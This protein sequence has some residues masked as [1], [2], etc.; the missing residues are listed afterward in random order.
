M[1]VNETITFT[2]DV[3][4]SAGYDVRPVLVQNLALIDVRTEPSTPL[5]G[6]PAKRYFT[7]L[8]VKD[9][10]AKVQF[11]KF[12]R[13]ELPN[14][15]YEDPL[16]IKVEKAEDPVGTKLAVGGWTSFNKPTP[17]DHDA[18]KEVLKGLVGVGYEPLLVTKQVVA[19]THFI[20]LSRATLVYPG[21]VPYSA[22]VHIYK[23]PTAEAKIV[24]IVSLGDPSPH[25]AGGYTAFRGIETEQEALDKALKDFTGSTFE[26]EYVS[27]QVV[28]GTNYRFAGNL[29]LTA[30]D[31]SHY[32][33][34]LTVYAPLFG[35]PVITGI[36][37]VFDLV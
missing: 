37:K 1:K 20:F 8:A 7:F 17:V 2:R 31:K 15:I 13:W 27:T 28:A 33:A 30:K 10:D 12:R 6:A 16:P 25:F 23:A 22:L 11:A 3:L 35:K 5:F 26:P 32:P 4:A 24:K 29:T 14:A 34:F 19:G 18:F 9:G 21:S 36:E